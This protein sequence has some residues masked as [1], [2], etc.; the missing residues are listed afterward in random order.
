MLKGK[1]INLYLL[2]FMLDFVVEEVEYQ[3]G[4][5]APLGC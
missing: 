2:D 3:H 1:H 5:N 4:Q